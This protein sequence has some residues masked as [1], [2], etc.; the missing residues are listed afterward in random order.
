MSNVQ[1][2]LQSIDQN[3]YN[4]KLGD[5]ISGSFNLFG[6]NAGLF[7]GY[8]VVVFL[9]STILSVIP[10][11]GFIANL[12]ISSTL[13]A[14]Y[15][16]GAH[17]TYENENPSFSNFFDGFQ[18][19]AQLFITSLLSGIFV[20]IAMI[21][22]LIYLSLTVGLAA[23]SNVGRDMSEIAG[24][25]LGMNI[26]VVFLLLFLGAL[27][28]VLFLYAP[29]FVLFDDMEAWEAIKASANTVKKQFFM[30]LLFGLVWG[31]I[32]LIS[33]LPLFLGLLVTIPAY[34]CSVYLAWRDITKYTTDDVADEDDMM[35]HLIE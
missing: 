13:T 15:Y 26:L 4:F 14:G 32:I 35:R 23:L 6:R 17:K 7:I 3:G 34:A 5:Y 22:A 18:K 29:F 20:L 10:F 1:S 27:V 21:P 16:I 28:G 25:F 31:I 24:L 30:H 9:I 12:L 2:R 8:V 19:W 33:A 11:V